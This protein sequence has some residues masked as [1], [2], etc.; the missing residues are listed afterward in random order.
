MG[1]LFLT[2]GLPGSG[3]TTWAKSKVA[4]NPEK[5]VRVNRDE[6]REMMFN[7]TYTTELESFLLMVRDFIIKQA[8]NANKIVIVDETSLKEEVETRIRKL[9][10]EFGDVDFEIVDFTNVPVEVCIERDRNRDRTVGENVI[11][12]LAKRHNIS[13]ES[14]NRIPED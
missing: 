3:K 7:Y 1:K 4:E 10:G 12:N 14:N 5:Y 6:L 11:T 9:L 13:T 2:R 8:L